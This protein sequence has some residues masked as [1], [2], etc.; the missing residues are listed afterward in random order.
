MGAVEKLKP[1]GKDCGIK[2]WLGGRTFHKKANRTL[3][4][5]G[6]C[7]CGDIGFKAREMVKLLWVAAIIVILTVRGDRVTSWVLRRPYTGPFY[8]SASMV[9][10]LR[11]WRSI[12]NFSIVPDHSSSSQILNM[13]QLLRKFFELSQGRNFRSDQIRP[14]QAF[15]SYLSSNRY[16]RVIQAEKRQVDEPEIIELDESQLEAFM[17]AHANDPSLVCKHFP[18]T[19]CYTGGGDSSQPD[20]IIRFVRVY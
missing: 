20:R 14:S 8:I 4:A 18:R 13:D 1:A 6:G 9:D 3:R 19:Q 10:P 7:S 2:R 16:A 5:T 11:P 15:P 12:S 17:K